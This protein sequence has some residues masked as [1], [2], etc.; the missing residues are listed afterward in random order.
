M[1]PDFLQVG[2]EQMLGHYHL[3]DSTVDN[4]IVDLHVMCMSQPFV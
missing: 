2:F 3:S 4:R 1:G